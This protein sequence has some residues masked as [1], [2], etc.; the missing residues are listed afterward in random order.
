MTQPAASFQVK[1]LENQ[2]NTTLFDRAHNRIT[3]TDEGNHIYNALQVKMNATIE[4][5]G[6]ASLRL[7]EIE[8]LIGVKL[9]TSGGSSLSLEAI[10]YFNAIN[11]FKKMF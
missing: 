9:L 8:K 1:Q 6:A 10:N 4:N 2:F 3:P 7:M 11:D 5:S